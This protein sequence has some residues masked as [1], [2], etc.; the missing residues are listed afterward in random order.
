M[1]QLIASSPTDP[2][3]DH[4]D[5]FAA[6]TDRLNVMLFAVMNMNLV[7]QD[8]LHSLNEQDG[9]NRALPPATAP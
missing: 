5:R 8:L 2:L 9:F 7:L 6:V 4:T 1:T 3:P